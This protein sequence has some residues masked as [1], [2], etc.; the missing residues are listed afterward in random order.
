MSRYLLAYGTQS[1]L[2]FCTCPL[3]GGKDTSWASGNTRTMTHVARA[4]MNI[5]EA[6]DI[7]LRTTKYLISPVSCCQRAQVLCNT[8]VTNASINANRE[9]FHNSPMLANGLRT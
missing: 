8:K 5:R 2:P 1:S 6:K 3:G 9:K 7:K 4:K